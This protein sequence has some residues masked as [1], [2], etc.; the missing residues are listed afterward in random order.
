[1]YDLFSDFFEGF[2]VYP[3][4][5][6]EARCKKCGRTYSDFQKTG[7]FG[8]AECYDVFAAPVD[9]SLKR[10]HGNNEHKGKIP[11][12]AGKGL[13]LKKK[14]E[15]LKAEIAAAVAAED[16]EKAASLHKELKN[17]DG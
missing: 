17:I 10:I 7:R 1:M 3:V 2:D 8:C 11:V 15:A 16:Y 4:Y 12:S 13:S 14:I 6:Q 5:R 9:V